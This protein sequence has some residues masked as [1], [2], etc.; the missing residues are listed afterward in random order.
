MSIIDLKSRESISINTYTGCVSYKKKIY[1]GFPFQTYLFF[2]IP[3][4]VYVTPLLR[5][6]LILHKI[7]NCCR[8]NREVVQT[9]YV[10]SPLLNYYSIYSDCY[11]FPEVD[12]NYSVEY[13]NSPCT[14]Y[15]EIDITNIV[16]SWMNGTTEN[17]G[18]LLTGSP[19][20]ESLVYASGD[21]EISAMHPMLRLKYEGGTPV[22]TPAD[23]VVKVQ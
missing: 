2:E 23:C 11:S 7:P 16:V 8:I 10:L 22:L 13:S 14:G 3:T 18:L 17:K 12:L 5:A 1:W 6:N 15:S 21:D 4:E 9:G 19:C 20:T